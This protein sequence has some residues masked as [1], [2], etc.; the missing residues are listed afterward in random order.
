MV[1]VQAQAIFELCIT[2]VYEYLLFMIICVTAFGSTPST[3][4]NLLNRG[5][6]LVEI[7]IG[8]VTKHKLINVV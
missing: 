5:P 8:I 2:A 4:C 1:R 6:A 3:T 7:Y